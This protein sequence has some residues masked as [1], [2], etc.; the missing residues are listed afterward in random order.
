MTVYVLNTMDDLYEHDAENCN[1]FDALARFLSERLFGAVKGPYVK[2]KTVNSDKNC[3]EVKFW[4]DFNFQ[5]L[6][7]PNSINCA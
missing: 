1:F 6:R 5:L 3:S 4:F 2:H 7:A